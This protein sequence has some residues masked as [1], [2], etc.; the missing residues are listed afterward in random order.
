M[1]IT[2]LQYKANMEMIF[3]KVGIG[4]DSHRF[5]FNDNLKKLI[6]G[7]III[8]NHPPLLGNSD[9]DVIL[10][11][12]TN[13]I[14]GVTCVNILGMISDEMCLSQ[15]IQDSKEYL[16]EAL[17]YLGE[18]KIVHLSISIE[19][20]S[21]KITPYVPSIRSKLSALLDLPEDSI[22]ITATSGEGLTDFGKGLGIQVFSVVTAE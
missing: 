16:F 13:A 19:C 7:G 6:L 11:S 1:I 17:K 9:A 21:P 18:L 14:S 20:K 5:D 15:G 8:E 12:V 3:L 2:Y 10:H 4:Q 22:G